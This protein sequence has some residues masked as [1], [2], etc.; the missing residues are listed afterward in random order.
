MRALRA[1]CMICA[2]LTGLAAFPVAT[3]LVTDQAGILT[4]DEHAQLE[5][6]LRA[7][8]ARTSVEIAVVTVPSLDGL[9]VEDYASKLFAAWKIGKAGKNNGVLLLFAPNE[10][11]T[12]KVKIEVG[13]GLE[14]ILTDGITGDI[15]RN[16]I[17][18]G[19]RSGH[20]AAG[21]L[22]GVDAVIAR[23]D[24][25]VSAAA[26]SHVTDTTP[27]TASKST[28]IAWWALLYG[29][30]TGTGLALL[31]ARIRI[32]RRRRETEQLEA[33]AEQR[34]V[35]AEARAVAPAIRD[36]GPP[37]PGPRV[38]SYGKPTRQRTAPVPYVVPVSDPEPERRRQSSYSSDSSY[39]SGSSS[40]SGSS[41]SFDFGGGSSGGGGSSTDL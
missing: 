24:T 2:V 12:G 28:G 7:F 13:Y 23:L 19:W 18:P 3:G 9:A 35:N 26:G 14:P 10:P 33:W 17:R 38:A 30:L 37:P 41:S 34:R 29:S 36:Y 5:A 20:R 1:V 22:A 16:N 4:A 25:P 32:R 40:D 6:K 39:G 8:N 21:I 31:W 15:G 11:P 27:L